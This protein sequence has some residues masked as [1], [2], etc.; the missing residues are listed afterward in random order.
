MLKVNPYL[1]GE[2]EEI[3]SC[4]SQEHACQNE[5]QM[6]PEFKL[7]CIVKVLEVLKLK[8]KTT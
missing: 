3:G 2:K 5:Q 1:D 6:K 8:R 7:V 4:L